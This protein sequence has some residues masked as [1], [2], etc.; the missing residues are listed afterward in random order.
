MQR[1]TEFSS[2]GAPK[3]KL[4]QPK[5]L[6]FLLHLLCSQQNSRSWRL[7][8]TPTLKCLTTTADEFAIRLVKFPCIFLVKLSLSL[9]RATLCSCIM[10]S[11]SKQTSSAVKPARNKI[12]LLF[13][14]FFLSIFRLTFYQI[15]EIFS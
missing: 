6:L 3:A 14:V 12:K 10:F 5:V 8:K 1:A 7:L 4:I 15:P 11:T 2:A 13:F 9:R